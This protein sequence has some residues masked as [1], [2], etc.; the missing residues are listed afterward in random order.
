MIE[1]SV[2]IGRSVDEVYQLL[3]HEQTE[4]MQPF[5]RIAAHK[6]E[7]AG[8]DLRARLRPHPTERAEEPR[9]TSVRL[10]SPSVLVD[11]R[12]IEVPFS[13]EARGYRCVFQAFEGHLVITPA[14]DDQAKLSIMGSYLAPRPVTGDL[15]D[16]LVDH[17]ASQTAIKDLLLNLQIAMET[18]SSEKDLVEDSM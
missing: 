3:T 5:L 9:S 16:T 14:P 13:W 15:D 7:E 4:W 12:S 11:G 17:H 1:E 10:G 18:V 6:G 8:F 2:V